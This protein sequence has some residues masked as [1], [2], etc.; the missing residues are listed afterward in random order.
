[1]KQNYKA[2]EITTTAVQDSATKLFRP[3]VVILEP[4]AGAQR[5]SHEFDLEATFQTVAEAESYGMS[6][7]ITERVDRYAPRDEGT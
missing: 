1:M 6:W 7:A 4:P 5:P 2:H 3:H